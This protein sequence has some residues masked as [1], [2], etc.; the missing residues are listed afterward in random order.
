M[1]DRYEGKAIGIF[2]VDNL[3]A[4]FVAL[5]AASKAA[6][7]MIQAV[8][9]NRLKSGACVKMRGNISDIK[10][11][12]EAAIAAAERIGNVTA[13]TIIASPT[14][15]TEIAMKMTVNK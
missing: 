15:D 9:R 7:V 12:M 13:S 4:A 11:A 5:D 14:S 8:E 3:V 6:D 10:A 1:A 2:E